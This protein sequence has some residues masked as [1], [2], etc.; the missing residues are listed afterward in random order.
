MEFKKK[1]EEMAKQ[2]QKKLEQDAELVKDMC[3]KL[4]KHLLPVPF[5]VKQNTSKNSDMINLSVKLKLEPGAHSPDLLKNRSRK[6]SNCGMSA[7][8]NLSKSAD[9]DIYPKEK[10][11]IDK[12]TELSML[13][14]SFIM[15]VL[16]MI[17]DDD[18]VFA[19]HKLKQIG[20]SMKISLQENPE[21]AKNIGS[22]QLQ[23]PEQHTGQEMLPPH[24]L[25]FSPSHHIKQEPDIGQATHKSMFPGTKCQTFEQFQESFQSKRG[26]MN[27]QSP[28]RS[29]STLSSRLGSPKGG[30][31]WS[32]SVDYV[33]LTDSKVAV[34]IQGNDVLKKR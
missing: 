5:D 6:S 13:V 29:S 31:S 1:E 21:V 16:D 15:Q 12:I 24:N 11:S 26:K 2:K 22:P 9:S 20:A 10:E 4:T 14:M 7:N 18:V 25:D 33:S 34:I 3:T 30:A 32:Q 27:M 8:G 19:V 23:F 28:A 17:M